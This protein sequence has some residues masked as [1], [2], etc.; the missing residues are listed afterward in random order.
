VG[1]GITNPTNAKLQVNASGIDQIVSAVTVN[2]S[3]SGTYQRGVLLLNSG[4]STDESLLY[5][6]GKEQVTKN[7]GQL[8]FHYAGSGSDSNRLGLGLYAVDNIVNI[9][10]SGKVAINTTTDSGYQFDVNGTGRFSGALT[11]STSNSPGLDIRK[12]SSVDNRYLRLTNTQTSA[13]AWDLINQTNANS[14]KFVVYNATD[15]IVTLEILP[16]GA[17]TF[18]STVTMAGGTSG[19]QFTF[20]TGGIGMSRTQANNSIWWNGGT[21]TNHVLWNDYYGGP[22]TRPLAGTGFDG[23]KWNVYRGIFIQGGSAGASPCLVIQNSATST[24]DHTVALYA[25]GTKRFETTTSGI[26]VNNTITSPG[27]LIL[28]STL[29]SYIRPAAAYWAF[30]DTGN[31][32]STG[33]SQKIAIGSTTSADGGLNVRGYG[34]A[35]SSTTFGVILSRGTKIAWTDTGNGTTG[36]YIYS[37]TGSPYSVTI[38]S[39]GYNAIACPNTGNVFIN[40]EAGNLGVGTDG[41]SYKLHVNGT[42]Y[43][44]GAAGSLS[45]IR[46]KN[47]VVSTSKGLNEILQLNPVEFEWNED[48]II[49]KGME[50][51]HLGFI[52][53]EVANI[54]PN[55]ILVEPN[56]EETLGI[57]YNELIPVL[58]NA[59]KELKAEIEILK[60]K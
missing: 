5:M 16:A 11:I 29:N 8:Y 50:G 44:T 7:A 45:D 21:D 24:E 46:H 6:V 2:V 25:S 3:G 54:L 42:A 26:W 19:A 41:P 39:G 15:N 34:V 23:I 35:D 36:E 58:V 20:G 1:I 56:E 38:H 52:A 40:Y 9:F 53:Q 14:N 43:A 59:I 28:T 17:A 12:D 18:T 47:N 32:L 13:K 48:K 27:N 30:V 37:Q 4:L 57:K 55:T 33:A 60:N 10:A 51:T 22:T 31:G 49:D